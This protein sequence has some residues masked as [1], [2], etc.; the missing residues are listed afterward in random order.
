MRDEATV[1][2]FGAIKRVNRE[3]DRQVMNIAHCSG[4]VP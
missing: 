4:D 2:V 3:Y 1:F